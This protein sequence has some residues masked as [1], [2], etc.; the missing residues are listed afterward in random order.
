MESVC[1]NTFQVGEKSLSFS[2]NSI[3]YF[4]LKNHPHSTLSVVQ[5]RLTHRCKSDPQESGMPGPTTLVFRVIKAERVNGE[6]WGVMR[7]EQ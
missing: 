2:S 6:D 5:M 7:L 3:P 1:P 4:C